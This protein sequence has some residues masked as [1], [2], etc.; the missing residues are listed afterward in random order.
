[1]LDGLIIF[2]NI[3]TTIQ[4]F[5]GNAWVS[6]RESLD[7]LKILYMIFFVD[8]ISNL[9]TIYVLHQY[10]INHEVESII[11]MAILIPAVCLHWVVV[12][13]NERLIFPK[14]DW[15]ARHAHRPGPTAKPH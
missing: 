2:F 15:K 13:F 14:P 4:I 5:K 7:C 11:L 3:L 6:K 8:V 1:M 12:I 10:D 9:M